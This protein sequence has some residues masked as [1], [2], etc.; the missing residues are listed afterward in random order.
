MGQSI[1][2]VSLLW[3]P[4]LKPLLIILQRAPKSSIYQHMYYLR[5]HTDELICGILAKERL[6]S[7]V[8]QTQRRT[9]QLCDIHRHSFRKNIGIVF[10]LGNIKT[11]QKKCTFQVVV[12]ILHLGTCTSVTWHDMLCSKGEIILNN[13]PYSTTLHLEDQPSHAEKM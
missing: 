3:G 11:A 5:E 8:I 1:T 4:G 9:V 7:K 12:G 2:A 10:N 13:T 6:S